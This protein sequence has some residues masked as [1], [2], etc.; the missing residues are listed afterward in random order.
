MSKFFF[1][2]SNHPLEE[3][4]NPHYKSFSINEALARGI[5]LP[6]LVLN[7]TTIDRNKP[8]VIL[9]CDLCLKKEI[10]PITRKVI[11]N[12]VD[13]DFSIKRLELFPEVYSTKKYLAE[14]EWNAYSEGCARHIVD[15][16]H[17]HMEQADELEIWHVWLS[18]NETPIIHKTDFRLEDVTA[19]TLR[20]LDNSLVST[21]PPQHHCY[22][23]R[24]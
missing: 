2:A 4:E 15:Y 22:T 6:E 1:F 18:D 16:I 9:W 20:I 7:S 13:D 24:K 12:G 23:I 8:N 21:I 10:D 19:E 14:L 5:E 3:I 17:K 11:D